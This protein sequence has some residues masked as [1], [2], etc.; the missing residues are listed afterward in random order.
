[1]VPAASLTESAGETHP[2][3]NMSD[4]RKH[5]GPHPEDEQLFAAAKLPSLQ[6]AVHD[7][8]WLFTRGYAANA[9]LK[10]V[11][12]RYRLT[13]RQRTAVLR[14]SAS[15]AACDRRHAKQQSPSELADEVLAIDGYN[16][17]IS[18]ESALSAAVLIGCRDGCVRDLASLHGTY[19]TVHETRPGIV[20]VGEYLKQLAPRHVIWYLDAPV[21]NSGRLAGLIRDV[22]CQSAWDWTVE[23]VKDPDPLLSK[24]SGI[25]VTSDSCVLD[26][27]ERWFNLNRQIFAQ[28]QPVPKILW[29]GAQ[30]IAGESISAGTR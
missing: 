17:L 19:R 11:G 15:D 5:R 21:S 3:G 27:C 13:A 22:A 9:S 26:R 24:S 10:I 12:D 6:A 16:L 1:M 29:L 25:V 14:A 20:A 23:L 28:M 4:R 18:L 30:S 8:S 2:I 7:L